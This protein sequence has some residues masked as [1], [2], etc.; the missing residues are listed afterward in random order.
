MINMHFPS[1]SNQF[2]SNLAKQNYSHDEIQHAWKFH[3]MLKKYLCGPESGQAIIEYCYSKKYVPKITFYKWENNIL[4]GT[5]ERHRKILIIGNFCCE[6]YNFVLNGT[7]R[8]NRRFAYFN[9]FLNGQAGQGSTQLS[10]IQ[11]L[12]CVS[13]PEFKEIAC[14]AYQKLVA[15]P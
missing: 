8:Q 6:N 13:F 5:D 14:K 1:I 3:V 9:Y 4:I 7:V 11:E 10:H 15:L 12:D 2:F